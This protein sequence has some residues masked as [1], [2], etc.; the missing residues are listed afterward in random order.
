MPGAGSMTAIRNVDAAAP[1]DGT[2][3]GIFLPGIITQSIVRPEKVPID[4]SNVTWLGVV[5]GDYSRICYGFG[6]NGIRSLD[7]LMRRG[8]DKPFI[9][10]TTG[11]G[12]SNYIN[13]MSLKEVF[14][15]N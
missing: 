9:M 11:T 15:A 2:V 8:P 6:P 13:G 12:A 14:G 3:V 7:G 1:K 5:S 10:G 4:F